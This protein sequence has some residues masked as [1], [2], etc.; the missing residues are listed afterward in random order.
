MSIISCANKL[1][2]LFSDSKFKVDTGL[3]SL[4]FNDDLI[5]NVL[6][7]NINLTG[8]SCDGIIDKDTKNSDGSE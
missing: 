5:L 7:L 6:G 1:G 8:D 4:S 3:V 2:K